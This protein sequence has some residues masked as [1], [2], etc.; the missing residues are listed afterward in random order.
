[1]KCDAVKDVKARFPASEK[2][3]RTNLSAMACTRAGAETIVLRDKDQN[4]MSF[5]EFE[6]K[7]LRD[8]SSVE[9][10]LE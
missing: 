4:E 1:M 9:L 2:Y 10:V 8:A 6:D 5:C 7:S 3:Q